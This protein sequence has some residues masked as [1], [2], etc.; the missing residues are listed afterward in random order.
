M[1]WSSPMTFTSN[2]ILTADQLNTYLRDNLSQFGAAKAS[3]PTALIM[4][5][6]VNQV[7]EK[8]SVSDYNAVLASRN[9]TSYGT[10][11]NPETAVISAGPSVTVRTSSAALVFMYCHMYTAATASWMN[12]E[13]TGATIEAADD[14]RGLEME[15]SDGQR[16]GAGVL[17]TNLHSGL[18][19]F[20]AVYRCTGSGLSSFS[21]RRIA[22]MPF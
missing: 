13:V 1:T 12:Y 22:V 10:I 16:I 15:G 17:H 3:T 19:T 4:T 20:T 11:T 7:D 5:T 18:N 21:N 9:S 14:S 6:Q 2:T 8:L